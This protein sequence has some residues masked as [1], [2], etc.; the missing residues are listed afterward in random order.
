VT[1]AQY[2]AYIAA[3]PPLPQQASPPFYLNGWRC[4]TAVPVPYFM[5]DVD[6]TEAI[7]T[8]LGTALFKG[9]AAAEGATPWWTGLAAALQKL[10][11]SPAGCTTRL[12]FDAG[13]AHGYLLQL[14]GSKLVVLYPPSDTTLLAR[15]AS[16]T[17]TP[18][19]GCDPLAPP[20]S[21]VAVPAAARAHVALL[22]PG[23]ALIIPR[24]GHCSRER[25]EK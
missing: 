18:Q 16:E 3:T 11:L 23:E 14:E 25:A 22:R 21:P 20:G 6:A 10:F 7:L 13:D 15:L 24:C 17:E 2:A 1:V 19:S 12:H 9:A 5:K 8:H 4:A